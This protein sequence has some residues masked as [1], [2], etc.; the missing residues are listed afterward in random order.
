MNYTELLP[1]MDKEELKK[2]AFQIINGDIKGVKLVTFF[3]FLGKETLHEIVDLLIE[4]KDTKSLQRALPFMRREDV[5]KIYQMA[6]DG[7]LPDFDMHRVLP[8]LGSEDVKTLFHELIKK[9]ADKPAED[10]EEA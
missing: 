7:A 9:A 4:K 8:F 1:F 2:V 3:P 5:K 6:L 10:D